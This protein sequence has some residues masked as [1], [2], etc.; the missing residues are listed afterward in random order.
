[1]DDITPVPVERTGPPPVARIGLVG[2]AAAALVA[3]G[4]LAAGATATPSGT[5]AADNATTSVAGNAQVLENAGPGF[6]PGMGGPGFGGRHGSG[7]V[8]IS[9]ISGSSISLETADGWTRTIVVDSGTTYSESGDTIALSDLA[10]GDQVHFEQTLEDDGTYSIDAIAV[11]PPHVGGKVTAISGSTI[12]VEQRDG[13]SATVNVTGDTTYQ[14]SGDDAAL[15]DVEVGMFLVAE[16]IENSDGSLTATA[17]RAADPGSM[18]GPGGHHRGP[19]LD[20]TAD[21]DTSSDSAG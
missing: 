13:T 8:T 16:G 6:G 15:A 20:D 10:V 18:P 3:V 9:A 5:L 12:T 11:I 7:G 19:W 14:V 17:V 1:M 2:A 21:D 4:I